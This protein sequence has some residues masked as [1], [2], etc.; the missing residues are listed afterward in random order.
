MNAIKSNSIFIYLHSDIRFNTAAIANYKSSEKEHYDRVPET[1]G[2]PPSQTKIEVIQGQIAS[3]KNEI[4]KTIKDLAERG[5]KLEELEETT[6]ML[7]DSATKFKAHSQKVHKKM[8][9]KSSKM[10]VIIAVTVILILAA[11]I[12]KDVAE[13]FKWKRKR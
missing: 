6:A 12:R 9:W 7:S 4:N 1:T 2:P 8:W 11:I 3:T 5:Q 13:F 10:T